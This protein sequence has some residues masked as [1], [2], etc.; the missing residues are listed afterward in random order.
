MARG[1]W[2]LVDIQFIDDAGGTSIWKRSDLV[3]VR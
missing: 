1:S 3:V 2:E